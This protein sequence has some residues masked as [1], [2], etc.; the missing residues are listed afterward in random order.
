MT[1]LALAQFSCSNHYQENI[2]KAI[3]YVKEAKKLGASLLLLPELFERNYFCQKM[4]SARFAYAEEEENSQTLSIFSNLAKQEEI[5]LPISFFE[6]DKDKFYNSI[7]VFDKDGR[8]LGK[9]RKTHIPSGNLYEEKY[10]FSSGDTGF[11]VFPSS[12]GNI[13]IG[14]CWDQWFLETG[15][16]LALLGADYLLFPTAIG[17]EPDGYDS[18]TH[19]QNVMKGQA[20]LNILPVLA[21]NR[22]GKE[23]EK[24]TSITFYGSSFIADEIG[25]VVEEASRDEERILFHDFNLE[26]IKKRREDWSIFD[27]RHPEMY[28]LLTKEKEK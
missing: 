28:H 13:G 21:A 6:K 23:E 1:R 2:K 11:Q 18:K 8:K 5:V 20:A 25:E 17:S 19:W 22:I 15:R 27:D 10:Y 12:A 7:V 9:Y 16:S 4:D 14:I 3:Y 24:D 26:K